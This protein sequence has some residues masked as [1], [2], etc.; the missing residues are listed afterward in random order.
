VHLVIRSEDPVRLIDDLLDLL[1]RLLQQKEV[2]I[3]LLQ[4]VLGVR[5]ASVRITA[6]QVL[7]NFSKTLLEQACLV[8]L[9]LCEI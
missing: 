3:S 7:L 9:V 5:L 4:L 8:V 2:C 6:G 1:A